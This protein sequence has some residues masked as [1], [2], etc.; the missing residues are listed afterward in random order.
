MRDI[1]EQNEPR[2]AWRF[3]P[4]GLAGSMAFVMVVNAG[5]V[6]GALSTFPGAATNDGFDESNIYN[7]VLDAVD[8]QNALGWSLSAASHEGRAVLHLRD[9]DGRPLA[10]AAIEAAALR[11]LGP[12]HDLALHFRPAADGTYVADAA[13]PLPGQWDLMLRAAQG[14]QELRVTRRILVK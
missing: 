6:W 7:R 9:R 12:T 1:R 4:L 5:M 8:K 14:G 11:P 13:L 10:G 2:S 3:Y